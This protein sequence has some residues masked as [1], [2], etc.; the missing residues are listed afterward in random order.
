MGYLDAY[1]LGIKCTTDVGCS[2][3]STSVTVPAAGLIASRFSV[4]HTQSLLPL[5]VYTLGLALGP[6]FIAPFSEVLGRRWLY[7][8]TLT[9]LMVFTAATGVSPN[10]S[11]L[12][13]F[14]FLAGF[15]GSAGMA[16]G[17]G[18]VADLWPLQTAGGTVGPFFILCPFLG[19]ILGPIAGT[20]ILEGHGNDWR[21]TQWIV[22][23]TGAPLWIGA[24]IMEETSKSWILAHK[25][26]IQK[27]DTTSMT[28]IA[29]VTFG[30]IRLAIFRS[31]KLLVTDI[32]VFSLT[33]YTAYAY[34]LTFS[35]FASI[36]YVFRTYYRFTPAQSSLTF[37]SIA[38]GYF[39]AICLFML[40]D[41]TLYA[42]QVK[43]VDG[44]L[45]A[46]EH[47]LYSAL[48]GSVFLSVGL[49]WLVSGVYT[50]M[51]QKDL[52]V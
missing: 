19:P 16:I 2:T 18:S 32:V 43:A 36:P 44:Q 9:S 39:L 10:F 13:A 28:A 24:I 48:A 11:A 26:S 47:R 7:I 29:K 40:F 23:I 4:G 35:Y 30:K 20:Y 33:L 45:P 52:L 17:G 27:A 51:N 21:W 14:R 22:L 46:P 50:I 3:F 42:R 38:I 6:L 37:I 25:F 1:L 49:F 5:T 31:A 15:L 8:F 12:L 34:A 41:R